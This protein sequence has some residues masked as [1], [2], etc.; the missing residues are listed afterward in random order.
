M[1]DVQKIFSVR[2]DSGADLMRALR[3]MDTTSIKMAMG[4]AVADQNSQLLNDAK[5][6]YKN[7]TG[8]TSKVTKNLEVG[9]VSLATQEALELALSGSILMKDLQLIET[10]LQAAD[11]NTY[12]IAVSAD[13]LKFELSSIN[14]E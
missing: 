13:I 8:E 2:K 1:Q 7:T 14:K 9:Q 5:S 4:L 11:R 6:V 3:K 12:R 10:I